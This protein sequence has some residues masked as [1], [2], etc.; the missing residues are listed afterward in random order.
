MSIEVAPH[1]IELFF[2]LS[3]DLLCIAGYDGYFKK[4]NPAV[5]RTLGFSEEELFSKPINEFVHPEDQH[6]T[7]QHRAN[8][9][10]QIPLLNFENRYLTK[11]GET[12]W[13]SW[14]SIPDDET[15]T[16]Y[17]VAKNVTHKKKVEEDRN[18]L[19]KNL[20]T[21]NGDLKQL[22]F[23]TSHNMRSPVNNLIKMFNMLDRSKIQD[24]ETRE[25]IEVMQG[26]T[27]SLRETLNSYVDGLADKAVL[28]SKTVKVNLGDALD[29][30][31][32][33]VSSL[34][35]SSGATIVTDFSTWDVV[36]FNEC[37]MESIFL[38]LITNSIKYSKPGVKPEIRIHTDIANGVKQLIFEDNGIGFDMEKIGNKLF[39]L[40]QKFHANDDSKGIGLYLVHTHI[41][42]LGGG[43]ALD[44]QPG[45]GSSFTLSFRG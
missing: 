10:K 23:A 41:T 26:A 12:V 15:Q 39:G 36:D 1:N 42:S 9:Q 33:S 35:E 45:K 40:N 21:L 3:A 14:T 4:V 44:S 16:V 22:T 38:N 20:T 28:K 34:I 24:G 6:L 13:L 11:S 43:I 19:I 31:T 25:F 18:T 2:E 8:L 37:Y 27:D 32:R 7:Q 17:G 29:S 5:L 30:V